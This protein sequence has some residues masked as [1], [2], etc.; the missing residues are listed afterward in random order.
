ML[1]V[2]V[3]NARAARVVLHATVALVAVSL[4]PAWFG[5]GVPYLAGAA[6]GGAY[7]V[8]RAWQ[9]ARRPSRATAMASFFASL[10]QLSLL[11]AGASIDG[12]LR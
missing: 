8:W 2:V 6:A 1:P 10:L 11:L 5:A 12:L 9:L 4:L 3:G 7:F